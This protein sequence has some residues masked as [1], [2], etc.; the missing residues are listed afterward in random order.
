MDGMEWEY[1]E[2]MDAL[3]H[4]YR[5]V[6]FANMSWKHFFHI[7][8]ETTKPTKPIVVGGQPIYFQNVD[9][10]FALIKEFSTAPMTWI[11][12]RGIGW[13]EYTNQLFFISSIFEEGW[14]RL[15]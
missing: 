4:F 14:E 13:N 1:N 9:I 5:I 7:L 6:A 15:R 11:Y 2:K 10:A 12:D 8:R 3:I